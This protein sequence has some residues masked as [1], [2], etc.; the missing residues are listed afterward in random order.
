MKLKKIIFTSVLLGMFAVPAI[1]EKAVVCPSEVKA[2]IVKYK[3]GDY[4]GCVQDLQ[5]YTEKDPSNAIAY[6]YM[7]IAYMQLGLKDNAYE[8]LKKVSTINSVPRL[9]SYALQAVKCME[10][11]VKK[12]TYKNYSDSQI[13]KFIKDPAG[14]L[15]SLA[16]EK[17]DEQ[18]VKEDIEEDIDIVRLIKGEYPSNIHPDANKTIQETR[19]LQEQERVNA[20]MQKRTQQKPQLQ[21]NP[22]IKKKSSV[23]NSSKIASAAPTDKEI[24]DAVRVLSQ[25]GYSFAPKSES[26]NTNSEVNS[27]N[28][29]EYNNQYKNMAE[30]YALT[31]DMEQMA[32]LFGDNSRSRRNDD[33]AMLNFMMNQKN[34]DGSKVKMD[35]ELI[36]TM[37]MNQVMGDY[38]FGFADNKDK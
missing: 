10:G 35:P 26:K 1:A 6:Y 2:S 4:V 28:N 32:M 18:E 14:F 29:Y 17:K 20:E 7:G 12:C 16:N 37:M 9:S 24:A 36:K 15:E 25:A 31:D 13:D 38:D 30:R 11:N 8:S 21:L 3:K 19:L 33:W 34:P 27:Q 22:L 5:E 23:E